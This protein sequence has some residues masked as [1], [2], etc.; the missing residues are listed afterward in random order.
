MGEKEKQKKKDV[1]MKKEVL[2]TKTI[3]GQLAA[4]NRV[5]IGQ[6]SILI[7]FFIICMIF[8]FICQ[9]SVVDY[10][11]KQQNTSEVILEVNKWLDELENSIRQGTVFENETE[12]ENTGFQKFYHIAREERG[13]V[14]E[15]AEKAEEIYVE[16]FNSGKDALA[17][18]QSD[19]KA[20]LKTLEEE[21]V[22]KQAEL[23]ECLAAVSNGYATMVN[24][25]ISI[26]LGVIIICIVISII[27]AV[28][29]IRRASINGNK[30]ALQ[31][32]TPINGVADWAERLSKGA[33]N[34]EVNEKDLDRIDLTEVRRM[35][36]AFL[37]M[38]ESINDNV[39]VVKKVAD[40][41][42][43]AFVNIRSSS[44]SLG[45]SLYRMVQN[46]DMMFAEIAG[47]AD[48]MK[49]E[50]KSIADA[51]QALAENCMMQTEK[52]MDFRGDIDK[53]GKLINENSK[54]A[55]EAFE[56]S[57]VIKQEV[58]GSVEKMEELVSAMEEIRTASERVSRV[59]ADIEEIASQT[60]LLALNAAIEAARAGEA[61]KGFAVVADSVRELA[62]KSAMAATESKNLIGDTIDK[63]GRGS[64]L[65]G[66]TFEAFRTITES[67]E[68]I[69]AVTK[70]IS[71]SGMRQKDYMK[72]IEKNVAEISDV[73]SGN[74]AA[75]QE[76][77][78]M[79]AEIN[80]SA[81]VL[82]VSM[83]QFNLRKRTPGKPYIPPEKE[84]DEEFIRIAT[85]NFEKFIN[86]DKGKEL[87]GNL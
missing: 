1:S 41:D 36:S 81:E 8:I 84:K 80:K 5:I 59:I 51:S 19:P 71:E 29:M 30:M 82:K 33:E 66:D 74:A 24:Q 54:D 15:R 11:K 57:N 67:I 70:S 52:I 20:A 9:Q 26:V 58:D 25:A 76:T 63:T 83:G 48:S 28:L 18:R 45:K 61:G 4:G 53:T 42:M 87:M 38:A 23:H 44:D 46:N 65:S 77:A 75:S 68:G 14:S 64:E 37:Q 56:L 69:I 60:N 85:K 50:A 13:R 3:R 43:T 27:V 62:E 39:K 2:Q 6:M 78:A 32:S 72:E 31:I 35:V 86:S 7:V 17:N 79:S 73:I 49:E 55:E 40:G 10:A 21:I 22:P 16:I 12:I 47:I 34:L